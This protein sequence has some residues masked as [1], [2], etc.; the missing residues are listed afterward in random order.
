MKQP[1][2]PDQSGDGSKYLTT[3]EVARACDVSLVAVK[4]WIRQG[5]LRAIRTPGGHF[6]I[7][8]DEFERFRGEYRFGAGAQRRRRILVVDD[9]P[10]IVG[11]I[12]E[13]LRSDSRWEVAAAADGY[14]GLLK[15]G[16]FR[17]DLL[18]LDLRMPRID[19]LEVCRR[20]KGE[21][22]TR[23]TKILA[24]S[25]VGGD[26]TRD[27]ALAAGADAFLAKPFF[28]RQLEQEV[29]RLLGV[30]DPVARPAAPAR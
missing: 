4:K 9:E 10:A 26:G 18:V 25:G 27:E 7:P 16:S 5:K 12:S 1:I 11:V 24:I 2:G 6:R 23:A 28:T 30:V 8:A 14:E 15:V 13:T 29:R 3:G 17:P 20:V 21:T 22:A 19:G